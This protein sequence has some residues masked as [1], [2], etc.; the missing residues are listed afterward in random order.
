[1][2]KTMVV[3]IGIRLDRL[4]CMCRTWRA[5]PKRTMRRTLVKNAVAY[6]KYQGKEKAI[7]EINKPRGMFDKG[8]RMY[9]HT[10]FRASWLLTRKIRH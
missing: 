8:E 5:L 2:K 9:S 4:I 7:A 1:M 3:F 10:I 6:V